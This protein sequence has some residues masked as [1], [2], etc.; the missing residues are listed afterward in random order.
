MEGVDS[1]FAMNDAAQ[2]TRPRFKKLPIL[3][4]ILALVLV[5]LLVP[6]FI[7]I[8]HYKNR[9]TGLISASLGRPVRLSSVEMRLVPW[10]GFVITDLSVAEDPAYG[11]E[12]V[13]H[14]NA[15]RANIRLLSL[16][17]GKL[18]ISSISVDEA[19]LNLV[20]AAPGK[21]NL[22]PLF[23]TAAAKAGAQQ[24]RT[25]LPYLEA[26]NS[27]INIKDG[28][29][30]L[31]FSLV[32]TDLSFWQENPG[33]WRIRLRGQPART[34]VVLNM[35][36]T[37]IVRLEASMRSAPALHLMPL[38]ADLDWREAQL[39]QL[40]RLV[41]G[42]DPG[43]RG[44]LTGEAHLDGTPEAAHITA[45]LSAT[46]VH[47]A[48]F[49]PPSPLDFDANC[50]FVYHYSQRALDNLVC[51]S[52]L[53]D[54]QLHLTGD[55]PAGASPD[56]TLELDRVPA[57]AGLDALRTVRSGFAA[58]L[59][60]G[61]TV[62]GKL[63]YAPSV[64]EPQQIK[65][66]PRAQPVRGRQKPVKA[67]V[68]GPDNGLL[69][70]SIAVEGFTLSGGGLS[71]PLRVPRFVLEPAELTAPATAATNDR[72]NA[73]GAPAQ[74]LAGTVAIPA[75]GAG[76]LTFN[77]RLALYGYQAIARGQASIQR[78]R[79][80]AQLAGVTQGDLLAG[81][82][83]DPVSV[84][85]TAEGPWLPG[86]TAPALGPPTA[87]V[88][89]HST[90]IRRKSAA[91]GQAGAEPVQTDFDRGVRPAVDSLVGT[92]TLRD[93]NWRADYLANRVQI[94]EATLHLGG[95]ATE[96]DPIVFT[97]GPV[98]G[99]ASVTLPTNCATAEASAPVAGSEA[100]PQNTSACEPQFQAQ[101]VS[102]NAAALQNAFLGA[103]QPGTVLSKLIDRLSSSSAPP[104]PA[105][106]G[107]IKA[108]SM[109]LG[110]LTAT[111]ASA[112]VEITGNSADLTD[113]DAALLGGQF[114]GTGTLHWVS[115]NQQQP[116][117]TIEGHLEQLS[118]PA[119]GQFL[120]MRWTGGAINLDGTLDVSGFA[121]ADLAASAKGKL[122]FEWRRGAV[123]NNETDADAAASEI[124]PALAHFD[125]WSGDAKIA[126][127]AI[128]LGENK[129]VSG[130][131]N[132]PVR[133]TV[134]LANPPKLQFG[135]IDQLDQ[136]QNP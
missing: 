22:D 26:T 48:E 75:G 64:H 70:G 109:I 82:A 81:L 41:L 19:T 1:S 33:E 74:I 122:H 8:G 2:P 115:G 60:A 78:A 13:L 84:N 35:G 45:R 76:P 28:A 103:R 55:I 136:P 65:L 97:Y 87:T 101:F 113:V 39:G 108:D 47:R 100:A 86:E 68:N 83:G 130:R 24:D 58:D 6:P 124:P 120:D 15:V 40:S 21:W 31:P 38:H 95:M 114:H 63:A 34:D 52:P 43:W 9:I 98:K 5:L 50:G 92:V 99:T 67:P 132:V 51:N 46:G 110:P 16:W 44:D 127:G 116:A 36:D 20:H 88:V 72:T 14:A 104:W 105:M 4:V 10:P 96:W 25:P 57:A 91:A 59:E 121:P 129:L 7:S 106:H 80:I 94:V 111:H 27:R 3:L 135:Q 90:V 61:G 49:T 30:K 42:S 17:R 62:S 37:G 23:R 123:A 112:N 93:A 69:T 107:T 77:A 125:E 32:N 118:A 12:P 11:A 131:R 126:D 102:L 73:Q 18:E 53:G 71:Q 119:V 85:V 134:Q 54:G 89:P 117:Y 56:L 29:E 133:A 66:K 79:E 128:T